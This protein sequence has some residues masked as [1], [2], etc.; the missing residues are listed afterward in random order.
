VIGF[1]LFV[2]C[3]FGLAM[4]STG[5]LTAEEEASLPVVRIPI[6]LQNGQRIQYSIDGENKSGVVSFTG[7][8]LTEI[9]DEVGSPATLALYKSGH[10]LRS[11][12]FIGPDGNP[13]RPRELYRVEP[14]DGVLLRAS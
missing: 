13:T 6:D 9:S 7:L 2:F 8:R 14:T 1:I 3:V 12:A 5:Y 4:A 11:V 10:L